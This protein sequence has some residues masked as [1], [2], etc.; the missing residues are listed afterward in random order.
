MKYRIIVILVLIIGIWGVHSVSQAQ[1]P[2]I[3]GLAYSNDPNTWHVGMFND[4]PIVYASNADGQT[5]FVT[6]SPCGGAWAT[7]TGGM[8]LFG[9][10]KSCFGNAG[11]GTGF[12]ASA[13]G[14][15]GSAACTIS[16]VGPY[17]YCN[18]PSDN[19][20]DG[21]PNYL[22]QCVNVPGVPPSGC[23]GTVTVTTPPPQV[24]TPPPPPI[25]PTTTCDPD[26]D[27][28]CD[29]ACPL[30]PG[31]ADSPLGKGCPYPPPTTAPA[32]TPNIIITYTPIAPDPNL[33]CNL[34][35]S[36][37]SNQTNIN[38][39]SQPSV[40]E[41]NI[42]GQ[43]DRRTGMFTVI[44]IEA[45]SYQIDFNGVPGWVH[46]SVS[47][48]GG[49]DCDQIKDVYIDTVMPLSPE[50]ENQV[51]GITR[52]V[53]NALNETC[54]ENTPLFLF[55]AAK[56]AQEDA[57]LVEALVAQV[58]SAGDLCHEVQELVQGRIKLSSA[59]VS[60]DQKL[61]VLIRSC[62]DTDDTNRI[63][64][65]ADQMKALKIDVSGDSINVC[66]TI[67]SVAV[68]GKLNESENTLYR[69]F[70][71][72]CQYTNGEAYSWVR[73]AIEQ[74]TDL[75]AL[76]NALDTNQSGLCNASTAGETIKN[77]KVQINNNAPV[78]LR[79]AL[80]LCPQLIPQLMR[81]EVSETVR[82]RILSVGDACK[83]AYHY[84]VYE[85]NMIPLAPV[86]PPVDK[87]VES[88]QSE[89]APAAIVSAVSGS[90][91]TDSLN[92]IFAD[93]N[94][95]QA[96]FIA[97][98]KDQ[99]SRDIY[100][101]TGG[102]PRA[103]TPDTPE[104]ESSPALNSNGN[105]A[106]L[107]TGKDGVTRLVYQAFPTM[108]EKSEM[109]GNASQITL[110]GGY[111]FVPTSRLAW[112]PNGYVLWATIQEPNG[113]KYIIQLNPRDPE[114]RKNE[115]TGTTDCPIYPIIPDGSNPVVIRG[116]LYYERLVDNQTFIEY[117]PVTDL[118][119]TGGYRLP[120]QPPKESCYL[121]SAFNDKT[122]MFVCSTGNGSA[123]YIGNVEKA[124]QIIGLE[125]FPQVHHL[126]AMYIKGFSEPQYLTFDDGEK[127][128][129]LST[130]VGA[131]PREGMR[132]NGK[133]TGVTWI[134][135]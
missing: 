108:S 79:D 63:T 12:N 125:K 44:G 104:D 2:T 62:L 123:I 116:Y 18:V 55:Y 57:A 21:V 41:R 107:L 72:V 86:A 19:D 102:E 56:L 91:R 10:W 45:D 94:S 105:F 9:G 111:Q 99:K 26:G 5:F 80:Q 96:L 82:N 51:K 24:T 17:R 70:V 124:N 88:L 98:S 48:I 74:E 69:K 3:T 40:N 27:G 61:N 28:I 92:F 52:E 13:G 73:Y 65:I 90:N 8:Q 60:D 84:L 114:C 36:K 46:N 100:L 66:E 112:Q 33:P 67:K 29:D 95:G 75:L 85:Q 135:N 129:L 134:R 20:N 30:V 109:G 6:I 76:S 59:T 32:A 39:R 121:P 132:V 49:I 47:Q 68:T 37:A 1:G 110:E 77:K 131:A 64:S 89:L 78:S 83:A 106:Y 7:F 101:L 128:Y 113:A 81:R 87:H 127:S 11:A 23:P 43:F 34:T 22:D 14:M 130:T 42:I 4:N 126:E 38:V 16:I 133:V 115:Q 122:I 117:Q 118:S 58:R 71:E 53:V 25:L 97:P 119:P 120:S 54:A 93:L 31:Y 103:L 50:V 15:S 35:A